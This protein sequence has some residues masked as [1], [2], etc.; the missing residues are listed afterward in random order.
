MSAAW[1]GRVPPRHCC[2]PIDDDSEAVVSR[3]TVDVVAVVRATDLLLVLL[4]ESMVAVA[5]LANRDSSFSRSRRVGSASRPM[6]LNDLRVN[7]KVS[8]GNGRIWLRDDE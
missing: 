2:P 8:N 5:T 4:R 6:A 7:E 3:E 1:W